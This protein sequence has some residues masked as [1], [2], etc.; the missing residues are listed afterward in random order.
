[1][2]NVKNISFSDTNRDLTIDQDSMIFVSSL[3]NGEINIEAKASANILFLVKDSTLDTKIKID[4]TEPNTELNINFLAITKEEE[5]AKITFLITHKQKRTDCNF[6][7]FGFAFEK[8]S[9]T[10]KANNSIQR[11]NI[12]S[13]THQLLKVLSDQE[14]KVQGEPGL[15]IDEF[16][17]SASHG[18]SIGQINERALYYIQSRGLDRI[19]ARWIIIEGEVKDL[20]KDFDKD[21]SSKVINDL[22]TIM[23]VKHG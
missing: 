10:I 14:A 5:K 12:Q 2:N 15:F 4:I 7:F 8:S 11:G 20:L 19:S 23:G 21:V 6:K 1:M 16:D 22:K 18:N 9:L 3:A 13:N 17:V